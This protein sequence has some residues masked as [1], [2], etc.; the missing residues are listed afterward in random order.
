MIINLVANARDALNERYSG[1]D[2]GK[3]LKIAAEIVTKEGARWIDTTIE[4]RGTGI[5]TDPVERIFAPFFTT[6]PRDEGTG[7]GLSVNYGIVKEHW[8]NLWVESEVGEHTLPC[9]IAL[10]RR[11]TYRSDLDNREDGLPEIIPNR[12]ESA[13]L[14]SYLSWRAYRGRR[15]G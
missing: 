1:Y 8:G 5:P 7:L 6:K 10:G 4:N 13:T 15:G 12:R 9:R 11:L 3:L 2:D 14:W